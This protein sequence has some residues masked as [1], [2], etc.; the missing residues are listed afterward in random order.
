MNSKLLSSVAGAAMLQVFFFGSQSVSAQ[1]VSSPVEDAESNGEIIVT[2]QRR[3]ENLQKVPLSVAVVTSDILASSGITGVETLKLAAPGVEFQANNGSAV[4]VIR[5]VGSK[6]LGAGVE[7]PVAI[8]VDGVYVAAATATVLSFNNIAQ[9]EVLKGPQGTLFGRNATGGLIQIKTRDPEAEPSAKVELGYGNFNTVSASAYTS[10]GL[11]EGLAA[12]IAVSFKAMG[13]GYGKNLFNGSDVY[14]TDHDI[15]VRSKWIWDLSD[16]TKI[17]II[18]DYSDNK[19][20]MN[21]SR[22]PPGTTAPAPYTFSYGGGAWDINS[23]ENPRIRTQ[24]GGVSLKIDQELGDIQATSIT[25]Y[26]RS[27][28]TAKFDIDYSPVRGRIIDYKQN[29]RQFSQELQLASPTGNAVSWLLGGYYFN[30]SADYPF[31]NVNFLGAAAIPTTPATVLA[32]TKSRQKTDSLSGFGQVTVDVADGLHLTGGL[33]YTSELRTLADASTVNTRIDG[34]TVVAVPLNTR[35]TRFKKL[36]W[37]I[38]LDYQFSPDVMGYVSYNRGFKSGGYNATALTIPPFEP[39]VMDAYETGLKTRLLDGRVRANIG[40]FYYDYQNVQVNRIV[41][42]AT[43]IYNGAKATMYGAEVEIDAKVSDQLDAKIG[44]QYLHG[45]YNQFPGSVVA[46]PRAAGG[47]SIAVGDVSGN[48]TILSPKSTL[49]ASATYTVPVGADELAFT[50]GY[51][52]NSG[53]FHEPDNLVRQPAYSLINS[54]LKYAMEGGLSV[55]IWGN[56]LT[57][58]AVAQLDGIQSFGAVGAGRK[59]YAAPRTYGVTVRAEF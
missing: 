59:N 54:S 45:K 27:L 11:A 8:Y 5:G 53:F 13:D 6:A 51:Y 15:G 24:Q 56:N 34:S 37:R 7:T 33:R 29:D 55:I 23:D 12:D 44:Y 28:F 31:L 22:N 57:N 58:E 3:S 18:G 10:G 1:E 39:E 38:A 36:T 4:P 17:R 40:G 46:T 32:T 41:N 19:S 20:S 16:T 48:R 25:A 49:S 50:A 26:R 30:A 2:A 47:Y 52:Y 43:G 14:K 21:A 9:I 42:G 35:S